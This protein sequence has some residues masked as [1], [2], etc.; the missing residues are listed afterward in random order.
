MNKDN[1]FQT[2]APHSTQIFEGISRLSTR[3]IATLPY[4]LVFQLLWS[5]G[6]QVDST[7]INLE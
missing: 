2:T 3:D 7:S 4:Y 6:S 5:N 1:L